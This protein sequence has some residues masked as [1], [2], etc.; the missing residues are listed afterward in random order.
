MSMAMQMATFAINYKVLILNTIGIYC[1]YIL[2]CK[3][4]AFLVVFVR[5]I[6]SWS[7][8][9][10]IDHCYGVSLCQD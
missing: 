2:L 8:S 9:P 3:L 7:L 10:R 6:P 4:M 5:V 1:H